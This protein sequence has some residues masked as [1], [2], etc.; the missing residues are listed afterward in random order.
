MA[1]KIMPLGDSITE[2]TLFPGGYRIALEDQLSDLDV[3]FV[4]SLSNGPSALSDKDHEGHGGFGIA[5]ITT[6]VNA[7]V[8]TQQ[9]DIITLMIGTNDMFD[10]GVASTAASR[11]SALIDQINTLSPDTNLVVA[12]LPP[13][14]QDATI[15]QRVVA[16]NS[17]LPDIVSSKIAQGRNVA[18][19]DIYNQLTASDISEDGFHPNQSGHSKIAEALESA[20]R[21]IPEPTPSAPGVTPVTSPSDFNGDQQTDIV[22][23]NSA[24]GDNT[25][26]LMNGLN[27]AQ[28][29]AISS[30]ADPSW[31]ISGTGDF[32]GDDQ[33]DILWRNSATGN[34]STWLMNGTNIAQDIAISSVEDP[35]W[36]VGG[37]G[38]FNGDGQTDILWRNA[39][40]GSNTVWMLNG[41]DVVQDVAITSVEDP[42]WSIAG[43]GN[44]NG[45]SSTDILWRNAV[46]G[47]NIVW[48]MDGVTRTEFTNIS[49]VADINW[50]ISGTGNFNGDDK[51]D[52]LWRNAVTGD[53][54]VWLMD[55]LT[56][57]EFTQISP[58]ADLNWQ[59]NI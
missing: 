24:T 46:T 43:T 44:F 10:P 26:W 22:W 47:D 52:I 7:W 12:S 16:F 23:R 34:N 40:T 30:V 18:L 53:N 8:N 25:V 51:T 11:L 4:G 9:P 21:S 20:I 28:D 19:V 5:E 42:N 3:D 2:G 17:A 50:S 35:N 38:D 55:G 54:I 45:D 59:I 13:F 36:S 49:P 33:S 31:S 15:N 41:T 39:V 6:S 58:V 32:N 56:R 1:L 27:V 57:T 37:T 14:T 29:V 48:L